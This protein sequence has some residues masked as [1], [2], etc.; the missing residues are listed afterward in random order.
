MWIMT[1]TVPG[2]PPLVRHVP[3]EEL[4][5]TLRAQMAGELP[6]PDEA[7]LHVSEGRDERFEPA[8]PLAA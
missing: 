2:E 5:A 8:L 7:Q 3:H 1:V 4:V 6:L